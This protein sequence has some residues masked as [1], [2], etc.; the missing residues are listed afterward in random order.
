MS[1]QKEKLIIFSTFSRY[2]GNF[3]NAKYTNTSIISPNCQS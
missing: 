2:P 1:G 3:K